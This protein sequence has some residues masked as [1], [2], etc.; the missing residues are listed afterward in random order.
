VPFALATDT[1]GSA[2]IPAA[3][4]G[5]TGLRPTQGRY[6]AGGTIPISSTR[7]TPGVIARSVQVLAA[8][9]AVLAGG[10]PLAPRDPAQVRLGLPREHFHADLDEDVAAAIE[11]A[12]DRLRARGVQ[13]VERDVPRVGELDERAGFPIALGEAA[14]ELAAYARSAG[15][16]LAALAAAAASAD[17]RA[18]L[19]GLVAEPVPEA[20]YREARA[21]LP[22]LRA[23]YAQAFAGDA[24]DAVDALAFPTVPVPP[25][26]AGV[27]DVVHHRGRELPL[28]PT[29]TRNTSPASLAGLPAVTI[30]VPVAPGRPPVGL[31]LDGPPGADRALLA[32]AATLERALAPEG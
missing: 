11:G 24:V 14:R 9:D 18:I 5:V 10:G 32:V 26:P 28:F 31:E 17:V 7:D 16:T 2:R 25:P 12:L 3:F 4:C 1:G 27:F 22:A 29:L 30:P 8:V 20:A 6:P 21:L 23:A 19:A 15:T 13:V